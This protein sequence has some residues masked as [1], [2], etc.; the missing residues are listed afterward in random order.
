MTTQICQVVARELNV[1]VSSVSVKPTDTFLNANGS[2][3]GGS[4]TSE[5]NC[6]V[7]PLLLLYHDWHVKTYELGYLLFWKKGRH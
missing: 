2:V 1:P 6:F 3:T 5:L 4:M 7:M